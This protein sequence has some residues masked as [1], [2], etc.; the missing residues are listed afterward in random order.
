MRAPQERRASP[1]RRRWITA[2]AGAGALHIAAL[3]VAAH[4]KDAVPPPPLEPPVMPVQITRIAPPPRVTHE[5]HPVQQQHIAQ[6][7]AEHHVLQ[8]RPVAHVHIRIP[9]TQAHHALVAAPTI[10]ETQQ[11]QQDEKQPK[12]VTVAQQPLTVPAHADAPS[13]AAAA[14]EPAATTAPAA[15]P[16]VSN[17][18]PNWQGLVLARLAKYKQYP[19][20]ARSRNQQGVSY[21]HFAMDRRGNIISAVIDKTSGFDALDTEAV[22]LLRRA[23]PFPPPPAEIA[24]D[25]VE[26]TVPIQFFLTPSS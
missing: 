4:W 19:A 2:F 5:P 3:L 14:P 20:A 18:V 12:P 21:V 16:P 15:Q 6:H 26:L 17:A 11:Q 24:G 9:K 23:S 25:P 13:G 8:P 22:A 10:A 1:G 7:Q